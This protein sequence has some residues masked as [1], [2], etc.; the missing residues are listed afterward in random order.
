VSGYFAVFRGYFDGN[1]LTIHC[2]ASN[3]IFGQFPKKPFQN[4]PKRA[5]IF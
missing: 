4:S 3:S 2:Q 5:N 1:K